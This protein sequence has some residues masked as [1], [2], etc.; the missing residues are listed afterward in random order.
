MITNRSPHRP[1]Q[2]I[3]IH[4]AGS[5]ESLPKLL[6][7][8]AGKAT[9]PKLQRA[10]SSPARGLSARLPLSP[11][12]SSNHNASSPSLNL[13][14]LGAGKTC[15]S[16]PRQQQQHPT[17]IRECIELATRWITSSPTSSLQDRPGTPPS[18]ARSTTFPSSPHDF[19]DDSE[20]TQP[21]RRASSLLLASPHSPQSTNIVIGDV[22]RSSLQRRRS[23][24]AAE[25][26]YEL[27]TAATKAGNYR[28][29][30]YRRTWGTGEHLNRAEL[31]KMRSAR[32][33]AE[34]AEL[35]SAES[36]A[37]KHGK[38]P[39]TTSSDVS[40]PSYSNSDGGIISESEFSFAA[41][42]DLAAT[43][44]SRHLDRASLQRRRAARLHEEESELYLN[45]ASAFRAADCQDQ[46]SSVPS[47]SWI[48][49]QGERCS[50]HSQ[51]AQRMH[52]EER[53]LDSGTSGPD[54]PTELSASGSEIPI[55][56]DRKVLHRMR[57]SRAHAEEAHLDVLNAASYS[58]LTSATSEWAT[59]WRP[60]NPEM[61]RAR[62]NI[63]H[64]EERILYGQE[65]TLCTAGVT[66]PEFRR[67][68]QGARS[69]RVCVEERELET[70]D[71]EQCSPSN[72][73]EEWALNV[74]RQKQ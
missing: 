11:R 36:R 72:Y 21:R 48:I 50:L 25:E 59:D 15:S 14:A 8:E 57:A 2:L 10:L 42:N 18:P 22:S 55:A 47:S 39:M 20:S 7:P 58:A 49:S 24:I 63:L 16:K 46:I 29:Q 35:Y 51:R 4:Q 74:S 3:A 32:A 33:H 31:H 66:Q 37:V 19:S 62:A 70:G 9:P 52:E 44:V 43:L 45:D 64:D 5:F 71:A 1:G 41:A 26:E 56:V 23:S 34:E 73:A 67:H 65:Q 27:A 12:N 30:N 28:H 38:L 6:V 17:T 69:R 13:A 60:L 61:Q 40:S 54:A 53:A 68:L